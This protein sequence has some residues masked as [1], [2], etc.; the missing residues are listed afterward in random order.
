MVFF[1][2]SQLAAL[3]KKETYDLIITGRE[4]IDYNGAMVGGMLATM[5]S[6]P[7]V[8]NCI[9]MD[10]EGTNLSLQ[11]EIDGGKETL[12]S[13]FPVVLG[14]QKGLVEESDLIIPN[15]RGIMQARQK[16]L[17]V[18]SAITLNQATSVKVFEKPPEKG[19][20]KLLDTNDVDGLIEL[21]QNEAKVL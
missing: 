11:R 20:V 2:A 5:L 18:E 12:S 17:T 6:L 3:C 10:V 8:A 7:Y 15:M 19:P 16:P 4:S 21:L 9:Q 14:A 13:T 1:V